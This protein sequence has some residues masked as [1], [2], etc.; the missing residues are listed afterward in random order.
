MDMGR[1]PNRAKLALP[2]G[3]G[4][5]TREMRTR[6]RPALALA[7]LGLLLAALLL[8]ACGAPDDAASPRGAAG[9][10]DRQLAATTPTSVSTPPPT[11]TLAP[12][13]TVVRPAASPTAIPAPKPAIGDTITTDG[14]ELT[15]TGYELYKRVGVSTANG[16]F[17]YL[18]LTVKNTLTVPRVFPYD[19]L[20]VVDVEGNSYF[21]HTDATRESLTY[22]K[23]IDMSAPVEPGQQQQSAAIFDTPET[24]TGF[25]LTTPSRVFEILLQYKQPSK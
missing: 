16:M 6:T 5:V 19:G 22:D 1:R 3:G 4:R 8:A 7:I 20:V 21:L 25:I 13:Q 17:L 24:A 14:W 11:P 12:T 9:T 23:G 2:G 15:V 18:D 10:P